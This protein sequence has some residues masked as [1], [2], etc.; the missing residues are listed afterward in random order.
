MATTTTR[1][2]D[3]RLG[4]VRRFIIALGNAP[5]EFEPRH[6]MALQHLKD[7]VDQVAA[8]AVYGMRES[9]YTD[10]EIAEELGV[11]QQAISKR[12]PGGG[13]YV[14]AAGRYRSNRPTTLEHP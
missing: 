6:L 7:Q 10:K 11:S 13:R 3:D 14:G 4:G 8:K 9:G 2:L 12:W 5:N 1:T